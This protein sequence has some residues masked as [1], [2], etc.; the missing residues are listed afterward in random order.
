MPS[1]A[2]S[3]AIRDAFGMFW[4]KRNG[5]RLPDG[6]KGITIAN[7]TTFPTRVRVRLLKELCRRHT[8]ANPSVNCFVTNYFARPDLK[9]KDRKGPMVTLSYS[10]AV[11][12]LSHHLTP[13][14][15]VELCEYARTAIPEDEL[16]DRFL[17]LN[18]DLLK[19]GSAANLSLMS[20]DESESQNEAVPPPPNHDLPTSQSTPGSSNESVLAK[21]N[22]NRFLK[23]TTTP[24]QKNN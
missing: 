13:E 21:K 22:R 15:L 2:E 23:K 24:Y 17:I 7:C 1:K 16:V 12:K 18:P 19:K 14:F 5:R 10:K 6:L 3:R 4:R 20:M 8:A 11:M 9:L